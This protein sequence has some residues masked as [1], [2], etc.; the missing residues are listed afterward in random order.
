MSGANE[1][2]PGGKPFKSIAAGVALANGATW[3][4]GSCRACHTVVAVTSAGVSAG[5]CQLQG[6]LDGVNWYPIGVALPCAAAS[7]VFQQSTGTIPA[8]YVRANVSTLVVGGT[9][10][11]WVG[12]A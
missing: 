10:D 1:L 8:R 12:S 3:D 2:G 4:N 6:S 7:T 9:V 11:L 5:G